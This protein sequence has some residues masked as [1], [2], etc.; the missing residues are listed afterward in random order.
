MAEELHRWAQAGFVRRMSDAEAA[1]APCVSPAFVSWD[2]PDKPR[3]VVDLRQ[4]NEHLQ[5]IKFKYEALSEF[6]SSL[7]PNDHLISWDIKDAY[8]HVFVHPDDRPYLTFTAGGHTYEAITM[9]FGLSVAPWAWTKIMRP[10]L[11][12]L[13]AGHFQLIGYVDDHG[14][15]AP[16]RRPVSKR[17]APAGFRQVKLLYDR[18]GLK[19][20]P[21]KGERDG[22]QQLTLLGFTIDTA[23]NAVRLPDTR[24]AKLRGAAAAAL[25][26]A[27]RNRR[28]VRR[29][30]L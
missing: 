11:A 20:H 12:A 26:A 28:W 18:L 15:A 16:G 6:M 5:E 14:A 4:V 27:R 17:D 23:A 30:L 13:R 2:R 7:L 22:T 1:A 9:P 21:T 19:L 10:V 3:L 24:V 8:H 25:G 29:K